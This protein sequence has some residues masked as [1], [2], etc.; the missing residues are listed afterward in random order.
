[1]G[2][3][4]PHPSPFGG[5][6]NASVPRTRLVTSARQRTT[7]LQRRQA[8]VAWLML[9]PT[10]AVIVFIA[11]Y[12]LGRTVYQSFTNQTFLGLVPTQVVGLDNYNT[13]IHDVDFRNAIIVTLKFTVL[14]LV[15]EFG[16]GMIIALVVNSNFKGRGVMRAAMLIPWAIPTVVSAQ[17]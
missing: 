15:F 4:R 7:T 16:L 13:L 6:M 14:T 9:V 8:R 1:M 5:R 3:T 17:D 2:A 12:P 11:L 10:I